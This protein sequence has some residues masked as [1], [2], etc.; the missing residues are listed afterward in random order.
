[1]K[2][3]NIGSYKRSQTEECE[4]RDIIADFI[5][6]GTAAACGEEQTSA[7]GELIHR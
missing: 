3:Y 2:E 5:G 4:P 6:A 7:S 1:M